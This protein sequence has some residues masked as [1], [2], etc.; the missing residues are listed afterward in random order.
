MVQTQQYKGQR[1]RAMGWTNCCHM[2]ILYY[3]PFENEDLN[4]LCYCEKRRRKRMLEEKAR[5]DKYWAARKMNAEN[6]TPVVLPDD[7]FI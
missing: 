6:P 4:Q 1:R 3:P 5:W 7:Y 2:K